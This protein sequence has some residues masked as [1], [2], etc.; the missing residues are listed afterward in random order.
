MLRKNFVAFSCCITI[1]C[2]LLAFASCASSADTQNKGGSN[3][4]TIGTPDWVRDPYRKFDKQSYVAVTGV[5]N[6]RQEAEKDALGKL[7]ATF[8]QSI[9]VDEKIS[10]TYMEA[11]RSGAVS[12]W[13]E[14]TAISNSI[15]TSAGMD[16]LVGA[17]IGDT[18]NDNKN[19]YAAAILN[20]AKALQVYSN[21]IKDN[22]A[23]IDKLVNMQQAEK[24]TLDGFARYQFAAMVADI[25]ISYGNLLTFIGASSYAQGLV[26]GDN[27]RL[28]AQKITK[29][30]PIGIIVKND[31][32][33][34]IQG[35]F[36]KALSDI[37]FLSGGNNSRYILNVN[38]SVSPVDLPNNPNKFARIELGA[39]LTD[40]TTKAVLLPY[41]FNSRE[42]HSTPAEAENRAYM[43]AEH[44]INEE[45]KN[46]L[47]DYMSSLLP[48][49]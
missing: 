20:K 31:K 47:L 23:M 32:A 8:G 10:T 42:G 25:N 14:N 37:G 33:G 2:L 19:Y 38:V 15:Q 6:S 3:I 44:K 43:A 5:G 41:N 34:R 17:E 36:A 24:N 9:Q 35:A 4:G 29:T 7:V 27:Y 16:S 45:Y 48:K 49:R 46:L 18:W 30:I 13:S 40:N 11:L 28:E 12:N 21:M 39:N 26:R 22:Q 1:F